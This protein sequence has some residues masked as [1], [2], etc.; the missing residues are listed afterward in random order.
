[1]ELFWEEG[2]QMGEIDEKDILFS[3]LACGTYT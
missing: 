2:E 1:M 3:L